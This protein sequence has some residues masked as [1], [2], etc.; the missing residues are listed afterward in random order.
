MRIILKIVGTVMML[1]GTIWFL[2]GINIL[3]DSFMTDK[4]DGLSMSA[5]QRS[6]AWCLLSPPTAPPGVSSGRRGS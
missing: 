4:P 3:P 2:Q 5:V 1:M 6:L